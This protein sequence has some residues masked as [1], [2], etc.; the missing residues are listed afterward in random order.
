MAKKTV[1]IE[2]TDEEAIHTLVMLKL[3]GFREKRD[4]PKSIR[5]NRNTESRIIGRVMKKLRKAL[6]P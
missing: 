3:E 2:L 5:G 6:E 1:V 4:F